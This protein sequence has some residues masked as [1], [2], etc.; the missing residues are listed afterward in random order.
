[1]RTRPTWWLIFSAAAAVVIVQIVVA[2][3]LGGILGLTGAALLRG[4]ISKG[5][6][7]S[8]LAIMYLVQT[9]ALGIA[10]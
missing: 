3:G 8:F 4:D 10:S 6:F 7:M 5:E 2:V 9:P 1:M